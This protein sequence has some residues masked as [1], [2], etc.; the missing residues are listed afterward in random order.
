MIQ[1][2]INRYHE[3]YSTE[4][5]LP[6]YLIKLKDEYITVN[7]E[8]NLNESQFIKLTSLVNETKYSLNTNEIIYVRKAILHVIQYKYPHSNT[9]KL[10]ETF[11][12]YLIDPDVYEVKLVDRNEETTTL[13]NSKTINIYNLSY[14]DI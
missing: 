14:K 7:E 10:E 13:G 4:F 5:L 8:P 3:E 1:L 12:A 2:K 6:C 9:T 11:R